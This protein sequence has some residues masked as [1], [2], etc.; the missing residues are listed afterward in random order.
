MH[1]KQIQ[2][3]SPINPI[4]IQVRFELPWVWYKFFLQWLRECSPNED[5]SCTIPMR[6][7]NR[8]VGCFTPRNPVKPLPEAV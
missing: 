8:T 6:L 5:Y 1:I 3:F 2:R 4:E 7:H